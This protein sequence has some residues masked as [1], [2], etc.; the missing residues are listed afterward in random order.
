MV[1]G[2][3]G[4]TLGRATEELVPLYPQPGWVE[5][6]PE[7]MWTSVLAAIREALQRANVR[8]TEIAAVG[9]TNQRETVVAY[10]RHTG[11][12]IYK[13]IVWQDR[14]T[15][16][17]CGALKRAGH[18]PTVEKATGLIIDPYFSATKM[19][20]MLDHCELRGRAEAGHLVLGTVETLLV[21]RLAGGTKGNAPHVTDV[22]NASRTLLMDLDRLCWHRGMCELFQVPASC[23]A[24]IVPTAGPVAATRGLSV[25]PDGVPIAA[26]VGDQQAAL[27]GQGCF[28]PG[29]VKCT[30]GTGAFVLVNT[31]PSPVRSRSRLLSTVAWQVGS[32]VTYALE[33][34]CFV[35][36]AAV[37]WLRDGLGIVRSASEVEALARTVDS[38]DG[39]VFVPALVGL[40]APHWDP[41]ARGLIT[42]ITRG[43]RAAH[44]ARATL[45]A[46]AQEVDDLVVSMSEDFG[47]PIN[48]M[49]VDG[50][51]AANDLLMELQS[52]CSALTVERPVELESTARGAA[53]L[54]GV[55]AGLIPNGRE[56]A[57]RIRMDR[58]FCPSVSDA[59]RRADKARWQAAVRRASSTKEATA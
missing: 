49:R 21:H 54:A 5:H 29:D 59:E 56:A 18:E 53:M 9:V 33:G 42:G 23:L 27:F 47:R 17:H 50:G 32:E 19:A 24:R 10:E 7:E 58:I 4:T 14:R 35:A 52:N 1:M 2:L 46:I 3:D 44:L 20:W 12:P 36:G 39:V 40:G 43:T 45:E 38:T 55:G 57:R 16:D 13:A 25:L 30:Y 26:L 28:D 8:P 11:R 37:Q 6:D 15:A 22:T 41:E 48:R 51:A 34:S 31:G